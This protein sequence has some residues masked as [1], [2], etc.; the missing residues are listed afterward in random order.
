M[1][2]YSKVLEDG[3]EIYIPL[4]NATVAFTNLTRCT[5]VI[6][7]D[8]LVSISQD[9]IPAVIIALAGAKDADVA[10]QLLMHMVCEVR[11][12]GDK[13]SKADFDDKF[14]G[15][16]YKA[17]ELF[18]HVIIAQYQS[19]FEQGLAKALSQQK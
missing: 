3:S 16:I 17:A 2:G 15:N 10:A 9:N 13:L 7:I 1:S 6:G 4:W 19:F 18:N 8:N 11:V 14:K 12:D 5:E